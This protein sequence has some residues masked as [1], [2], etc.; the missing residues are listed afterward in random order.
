MAKCL[1]G[2]IEQATFGKFAWPRVNT[3]LLLKYSVNVAVVHS[4][5]S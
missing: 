1:E 3:R 4:N 5:F 2:A